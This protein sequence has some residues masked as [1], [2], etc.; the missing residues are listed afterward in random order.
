M[1]THIPLIQMV[2]SA[3]SLTSE[4]LGRGSSQQNVLFQF[5]NFSR[6]FPFLL[7]AHCSPEQGGEEQWP[8]PCIS[9]VVR[10]LL[11]HSF[12]VL[13][14]VLSLLGHEES[15]IGAGSRTG[16]L[17]RLT[18]AVA[19]TPV[20]FITKVTF[21]SKQSW[22]IQAASI[23]TDVSKGTFVYVCKR[24]RGGEREREAQ[25]WGISG[26]WD[27]GGKLA[28]SNRKWRP[29]TFAKEWQFWGK[30]KCPDISRQTHTRTHIHNQSSSQGYEIVLF[31]IIRLYTSHYCPALPEPRE[32]GPDR[33]FQDV[34]HISTMRSVSS[35][36]WIQRWLITGSTDRAR[37]S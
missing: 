21:A 24:W 37:P 18:C 7:V 11:L 27:H 2:G 5:S 34:W 1:L 6:V 35:F 20:Q 4:K 29:L 22:H 23:D 19:S 3:H 25:L 17:T 14:N 28:A 15:I 9:G 33:L 16:V 10:D 12:Y 32:G 36:N 26:S 8:F 31:H 13:S 30:K